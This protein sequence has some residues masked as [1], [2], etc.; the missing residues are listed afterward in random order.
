MISSIIGTNRPG[1]NP[2]KI[3]AQLEEFYAA[4]KVP[5]RVL[6]LAHLPPVEQLQQLFGYRNAYLYPDRVFLPQINN[7]LGALGKLK[8]A[9]LLE[10][11]KKQAEGFV[12]FV[13]K[14]KGLK[15]RQAN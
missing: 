6:D 3:A 9:E 4:L 13:K 7:L 11:L 5:L 12:E 1:S 8:D 15:L 10:R 14:L 2:R